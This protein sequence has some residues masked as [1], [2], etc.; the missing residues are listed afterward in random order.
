MTVSSMTGFARA[1]GEEGGF[2]WTWELRSVNAKGLDVRAR[3]GPGFEGLDG[4]VRARA[5]KKMRRGNINL[6]LTLARGGDATA[7]RIND[8]MLEQVIEALPD[9]QR[10][11]PN[12]RPPSADGILSVRG[13]IE[14]VDQ[15]VPESDRET[16]EGVVLAGLDRAFDA[17]VAARRDEGARLHGVLVT[18]VDEIERLTAEAKGLA[19][20]RPEAI[21]A[22]LAEQVQQ[23]CENIAEVSEDRLAQEAAILMTKADVREELDRLAAHVEEAR[24]LLAVNEAVGRKLDFLCQEF[25]REANTL[26]SKSGDVALTKVGLGLKAVIDQLREQVQNV[27]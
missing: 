7:Y 22:R 24:A 3:L 12:V 11:L 20:T 18:Q 17:L 27:E 1:S 8:V 9:I 14:A 4:A 6:T 10:R 25:N 26:C 13:V 23:L 2:S 16:L 15:D 5:A 19:A 21:R